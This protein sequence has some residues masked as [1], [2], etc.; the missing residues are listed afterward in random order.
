VT[1]P[2]SA[3]TTGMPAAARAPKVNARMIIAATMPISSLR[4]DL[5]SD[6]LT[7]RTPPASTWMPARRAASAP[8]IT[9]AASSRVT[10]PPFTSRST[11]ATA[12]LP[13]ALMSISAPREKGLM[14]LET[15]A[16]RAMSPSDTSTARWLAASVSVPRE[17]WKTIALWPFC[18]GG[19]S[20][21]RRSEA[22]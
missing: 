10:W 4:L 18:C 15:W 3:V 14:T 11:W 21:L 22:R 9:P 16:V 5:V 20:R 13:S 12:V 1:K 2:T 17:V 6:S 7:P 19:N 8:A